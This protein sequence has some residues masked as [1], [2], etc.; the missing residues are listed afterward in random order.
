MIVRAPGKAFLSGEYAVLHGAPAVVVAVSRHVRARLETGPAPRLSPFLAELLRRRPAPPGTYPVADSSAL[1]AP[2]GGKLG[3]GSS[4]AVTV[5]AAGALLARDGRPLHD[6]AVRAELLRLCVASHRAAQDGRGSGGD[7]AASV[8]GGVVRVALHAGEVEVTPAE[9]PD[10]FCLRFFRLGGSV[11]TPEML[12]RVEELAAAEGARHAALM[13]ALVGAAEDFGHDPI[14]SMRA[15]LRR[16]TALGVAAGV[17]IV[18]RVAWALAAAA[19]AVGGAA[20]PSGAGGGDLAV[21][22]V[23]EGREADFLKM[24]AQ[25]PLEIEIDEAGVVAEN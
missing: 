21:A 2:G 4:A 12:R 6:P 15:Q 16:L 19:E 18:P 3:L 20:K 24:A 13:D 5:A 25:T 8:Y 11:S 9:L 10:G 7:V 14:A 1:E 17:E 23:P 22:L